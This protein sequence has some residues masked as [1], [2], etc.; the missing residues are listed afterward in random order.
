MSSFDSPLRRRG[1][2]LSVNQWDFSL[3]WDFVLEQDYAGC[4]AVFYNHGPLF[5]WD[6]WS[7]RTSYFVRCGLML[8]ILGWKGIESIKKKNLGVMETHLLSNI[9][10]VVF[11]LPVWAVDFWGPGD[12]W[13]GGV[14]GMISQSSVLVSHTE[15]TGTWS[16]SAKST[17][18]RKIN[19]IDYK[20]CVFLKSKNERADQSNDHNKSKTESK[21]H[22][23]IPV[24]SE[25]PTIRNLIA[26]FYFTETTTIHF[27]PFLIWSP[28]KT[29]TITA[30]HKK[31]NKLTKPETPNTWNNLLSKNWNENRKEPIWF[32]PTHINKKYFMFPFFCLGAI[33]LN[34]AN[35]TCSR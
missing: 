19:S 33:T 5:W 16:D 25:T 9:T 12:L 29:K 28:N 30:N 24:F 4:W 13:S 3:F 8:P 27:L 1:T 20:Y 26:T 35:M 32:L 15:Y 11:P 31:P 17:T 10:S 18:L 21:F 7:S 2:I 22:S 23:F 14:A 6:S 34:S